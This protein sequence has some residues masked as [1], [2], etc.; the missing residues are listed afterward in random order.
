MIETT[1]ERDDRADSDHASM[2]RAGLI[3]ATAGALLVVALLLTWWGNPPVLTDPPSDLPAELDIISEG[4]REQAASD[5]GPGIARFTP[6]GFEFFDIRDIVWLV[7]GI[8]GFALGLSALAGSRLTPLLARA[9]AALAL[10]SALLIA[11]TLISPPDYIEVNNEFTEE[12][13][14]RPF[15]IDYDVPFGRELGGWVA[16]VAALGVGAGAFLA[17]R[18]ARR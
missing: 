12:A 8:S 1:G 7:T 2:I 11:V 15:D 6:D 5:E 10:A 17:L 18:A 16:L 9:T 4:I 3:A 14:G 13:G